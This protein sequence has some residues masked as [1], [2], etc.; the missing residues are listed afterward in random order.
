MTH[1]STTAIPKLAHAFT[2]TCKVFS[3][4][5][6]GEYASIYVS[7]GTFAASAELSFTTAE[8]RELA[9]ALLMHAERLEQPELRAAA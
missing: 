1:I 8:A 7:V 3:N 6:S 5:A 9:A 2:S 4:P